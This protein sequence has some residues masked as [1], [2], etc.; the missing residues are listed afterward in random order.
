MNNTKEIK[1]QP[2][3]SQNLTKFFIF[4]YVCFYKKT[5]A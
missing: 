1:I 4:L 3:L 5:V 2:F